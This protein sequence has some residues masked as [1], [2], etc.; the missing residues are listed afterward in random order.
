MLRLLAST[1]VRIGSRSQVM[2][3]LGDGCVGF[4]MDSGVEGA[5]IHPFLKMAANNA[6]QAL[7]MV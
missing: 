1:C 2:G 6:K 7:C 4:E 5:C 3:T